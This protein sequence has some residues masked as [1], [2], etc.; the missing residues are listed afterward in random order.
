MYIVILRRLLVAIPT[1]FIFSL[2]VFSLM[3]LAP[4]DPTLLYTGRLASAEV[5]A[6]T[7]AQLGLDEPLYIQYGK[8][9]SNLIKGNLGTSLNYR[10]DVIELLKLR[11]PNSLILGSLSLLLAYLL[12]IPLGIL[13]AVKQGSIFDL[14]TMVIIA[15]GMSMPLFWLGLMLILFFSVRLGW[16]PVSGYES[17]RHLILPVVTLASVQ[18]SFLMRMVRSSMLE[19]LRQDYIRTARAKGLPGF[20]VIWQHAL[21]NALI[22]L[23]SILGMQIG[24]LVAGAVVIETVFVWPGVGKLI[25]DSII[26][27]DYPVIQGVLLFLGGM[28]I[29]GNLIAD[30]LYR[31]VDPRIHL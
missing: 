7:R 31:V 9:L 18:V 27:S 12:A 16:L 17:W 11:I 1:L 25:V 3:H 8:F 6:R 13:S 26:R 28:V 24:W 21:R 4:G 14:V 29:V 23:V 2:L 10:M 30:L 5:Y 20:R 19:V 15:L 22:P